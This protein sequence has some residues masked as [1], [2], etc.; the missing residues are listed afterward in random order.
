MLV[1][2]GDIVKEG[3]KDTVAMNEAVKSHPNSKKAVVGASIGVVAAL[4]VAGTVSVVKRRKA[5]VK[6][7]ETVETETAENTV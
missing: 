6:D 7:D 2:Y 1:K 3:D 4:A 5:A